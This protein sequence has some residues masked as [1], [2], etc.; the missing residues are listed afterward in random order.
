[1]AALSVKRRQSMRAVRAVGGVVSLGFAGL[2]LLHF[3][4]TLGSI[5][6]PTLR[7]LGQEQT[8]YFVLHIGGFSFSGWQIFV[9]EGI[10]LVASVGLILLAV[11]VFTSGKS[12]A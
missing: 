10:V 8:T 7:E 11:Y 1:M 5:V 4:S 9:L 12:S 2:L 6:L 3:V